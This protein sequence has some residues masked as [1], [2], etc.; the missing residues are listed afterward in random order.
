[1]ANRYSVLLE[2]LE[3]LNSHSVFKFEGK[4]KFI[5]VTYNNEEFVTNTPAQMPAK[6]LAEKK[7]EKMQ[8][9]CLSKLLRKSSRK[10]PR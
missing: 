1:M 4:I 9:K 7:P 3:N 8:Q 10:C 5:A 6:M 2:F